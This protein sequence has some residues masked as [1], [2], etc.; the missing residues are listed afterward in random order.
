MLKEY[1]PESFDIDLNGR[2][3]PWE[4]AILIPFADEE[5]FIK[6][7]EYLFDN[8]MK[9]SE[10]HQKRNTISFTFP[11]FHYDKVLAADKSA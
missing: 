6:A 9:L 7:E 2:T 3:L 10:Y 1:F 4:A 11:S 8:G 5:K